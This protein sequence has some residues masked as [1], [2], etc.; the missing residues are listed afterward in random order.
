LF[1]SSRGLSGTPLSV[2]FT[3]ENSTADP[4]PSRRNAR[5]GTDAMAPVPVA[6]DA[7]LGGEPAGADR[8]R[9]LGVV[10][11]VLVGVA[12]G[13]IQHGAVE[14]VALPEVGRDRDRVT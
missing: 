1:W 4:A 3:T 6:L 13:E 5:T 2:G 9:E 12:G 10:A 11:L 7:F 8:R 14:G